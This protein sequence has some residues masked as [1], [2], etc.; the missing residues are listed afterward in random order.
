VCVAGDQG[1]LQ[2][3]VTNLM[4][5]AIQ[6][7][8]LGGSISVMLATDGDDAV[9]SVED[10]GAGI[11]PTF[12]PFVFD[13]FRQGEGGLS[14]KHGGLGLGL[15]VVQQLVDLHAGSVTVASPGVSQGTT[16]AVRLPRETILAVDPTKAP[17][18]LRDLR[19]LVVS[20]DGADGSGLKGI[21]ESSGARVD[22]ATSASESAPPGGFEADLIVT[23]DTDNGVL[24]FGF[25][26]LPTR[27][28]LPPL[29]RS[30]RPG[31]LVRRVARV[32]AK[33][34]TP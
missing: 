15:A 5:N 3:I 16:F 24:T 30:A 25:P 8:P 32:M 28:A 31:D 22:I 12:L 13:Q 9:L 23:E 2:Q 10:T 7:T 17:L 29:P 20:K 11:E 14:R 33:T 6:F 26:G 21:L 19:V 34:K 18:L 4:T 1:R 27:Q